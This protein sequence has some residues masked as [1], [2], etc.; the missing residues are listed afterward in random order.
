MIAPEVATMAE[1]LVDSRVAY[2][3]LVA[4]V[5]LLRLVELQISRRNVAALIARGGVEVG[6]GQYPWIVLSQALWLVGCP[7]EVWL[8]HRPWLTPLGLPMLGLL[9][10]GMGLRYWTIRTL[11][12]RWSTR[13][14]VPDEPLVA[15]GP[16]RLLRHPNYLG[17]VLEVI[18]LPLVHSAWISAVVFSVLNGML[19]RQRIR[20]EDAA[21]AQWCGMPGPVSE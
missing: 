20:V 14:F 4:L 8:L 2:T 3:A 17:V 1:W 18:A 5:A 11:G 15:S 9:A 12:P 13:V 16:F 6:A 7:L 19:L 21:L 10:I